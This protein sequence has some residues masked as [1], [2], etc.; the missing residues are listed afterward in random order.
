LIPRA[1]LLLIALG[2]AGCSLGPAY[3]RPVVALPAHFQATAASTQVAWP[4]AGWWRGF[5]SPDLDQLIAEAQ[6]HNFDIAAAIARVEQANAAVEVTGAPLLPA[7][8]ASSSGTYDYA[9]AQSSSSSSSKLSRLFGL[10]S[11][12]KST[13][14][15]QYALGLDVS[16]ELDFW[17]KNR[18]ALQAAEASRLFSVFDQQVV[19][20]TVVTSVADTYFQALEDQDQLVIAR[21]NLADAEDLLKVIRAR[22]AAGTNTELDVAQQAALVAAEQAT[23]PNLTSL[24]KQETIALGI[25]VGRPPESIHIPVGSLTRLPMPRVAPGLPATLLMRRPDVAEAEANLVAENATLRSD[26][27]ALY[28]DLTLTGSGGLQSNALNML[29]NPGAEVASLAASVTQVIFDNGKLEGTVAEAKGRYRELLADYEKSV[30]QA[31]S[32]VETALTQ[33]R[34]TTEQEALQRQAVTQAQL[35]ATVARAQ[36]DAGTV[37]VTTVLTAEQ[38]LLSDETTLSQIRL[39]RFQALVALFKALGGGWTQPVPATATTLPPT[40]AALP[41][42]R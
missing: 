8:N 20:L 41:A 34:Y 11:S 35:A 25:L 22:L 29:I 5:G 12:S 32:D 10:S 23:I 27:A 39:A 17:G 7:L 30:V 19:A 16:Y 31:L 28:P 4:K 38:T 37:D 18:A 26:R 1:F 24:L 36:L 21:R 6:T 42:S 2:L 33:L 40:L 9:G 13:N 15:H 14:T 3:R